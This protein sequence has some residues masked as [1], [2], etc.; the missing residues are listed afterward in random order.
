MRILTAAIG[1]AVCA[2]A[3]A[4]AESSR[5]ANP[6][7]P[8]AVVEDSLASTSDAVSSAQGAKDDKGK[9]SNP[10]NGNGNGKPDNPGNGNGNGKPENPG[11]GNGNGNGPPDT[12]PGKPENPGR[13]DSPGNSFPPGNPHVP[14]PPGNSTPPAPGNTTPPAPGNTTPPAP[15]NTTP[16]APVVSRVQIQGVI[17]SIGSGTID[18][19]GQIVNVVASTVIRQGN[20]KFVFADLLVGDPVHVVARRSVSGSGSTATVSIEASEVKL[21]REEEEEVEEEEPTEP[22]SLLVSVGALDGTAAEAG[23]ESGTFRFSRSGDTTAGLVVTIEVSGTATTGSDFVALPL[24]VTFDAGS[25][26]ADVVVVPLADEATE[27]PET[28]TVT[29]IDTVDYDLGSPATATVTI[30][31]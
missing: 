20:Q 17:G 15:G 16:P 27:V 10:G 1:V 21:Q 24:T 14:P 8:S 4:C 9:P 25:T 12:P 28:V 26:T 19:N 23:L 2:L 7:A 29:V 6:T 13:P 11:N 5:T 30:E 3:A 22:P 31:G 18:V